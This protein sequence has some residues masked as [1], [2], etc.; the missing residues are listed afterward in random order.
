MLLP[1]RFNDQ[2]MA[3]IDMPPWD[4]LAWASWVRERG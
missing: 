2:E 1:D 4:N 3:R